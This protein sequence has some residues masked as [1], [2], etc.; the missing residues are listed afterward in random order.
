MP[1]QDFCNRVKCGVINAAT[2]DPSTLF[3]CS[4]QFGSG[5]YGPCDP[6]CKTYGMCPQA[7]AT[8]SQPLALPPLTSQTQPNALSAH[9]LI[10]PVPDIT[11]L[12]SPEPISRQI[13]V[14]PWCG[15]NQNIQRNPVC[16]VL[17][18]LGVYLL[19]RGINR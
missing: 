11:A 19:M 7:A 10:K 6:N 2:V 14:S 12:Y 8:P 3:Q 15:L 13:P 1:T 18:L 9:S 16:S 17:V 5:V 4:Q